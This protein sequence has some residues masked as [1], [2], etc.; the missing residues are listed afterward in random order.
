L[1]QYD[2]TQ[3]QF[4]AL[5]W[6]ADGPKNMKELSS[7]LLCDPSNMT[8]VAAILERKGLITRQRDPNDRRV[9]NLNLT[10]AGQRLCQEVK[11]QHEVYTQQR[12]GSLNETERNTL[13]TLLNKLGEDLRQQLQVQLSTQ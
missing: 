3:V 6:L 7:D 8:R 5:L 2:L 11:E 13:L 10:D 1:S 4:Y 12:M 9:I